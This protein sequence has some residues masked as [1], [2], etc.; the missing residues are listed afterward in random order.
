MPVL[1][2][3]RHQQG[4]PTL[5]SDEVRLLRGA[6]KPLMVIGGGVQMTAGVLDAVQRL[7]ALAG[8]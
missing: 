6:K 4:L 5:I 3:M 2:N 8:L 7:S 1:C